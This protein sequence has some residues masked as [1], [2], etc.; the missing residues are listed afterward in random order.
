MAKIVLDTSIIID[1]QRRKDKENTLLF[2]LAKQEH[3]LYASIVT[4]AESYAGKSVWE[5]K[6]V[7]KELE[8]LFSGIKTLSLDN[9]IAKKSGEIKAKYD[10]DIVDAI[11]AAT[12]IHHNLQ[13]ATLNTKDFEKIDKINLFS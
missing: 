13:L 7:E 9:E 1:F 12:A 5:R 6:K 2:K 11:I 4:Y 3:Q 8:I 10:I